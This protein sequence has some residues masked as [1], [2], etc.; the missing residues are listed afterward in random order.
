MATTYATID[1]NAEYYENAFVSTFH[2]IWD[3]TIYDNATDLTDL[4]FYRALTCFLGNNR[5][6]MYDRRQLLYFYLAHGGEFNAQDGDS[7]LNQ[8]RGKLPIDDNVHYILQNICTLYNQAPRRDFGKAEDKMQ[9]IYDKATIDS[10][11]RYLQQIAEVVKVLAVS[12]VIK[13][14]DYRLIYLTPDKFR[15]ETDPNNSFKVTK[16]T[17]TDWDTAR[18]VIVYNEWTADKYSIYSMNIKRDILNR[19]TLVKEVVTETDNVYGIIPFVFLRLTNGSSFIEGGRLDLIEK[20]LELNKLKF[21]SNLDATFNGSPMKLAINMSGKAN[22]ISPNRIFEFEGVKVGEGFNQAPSLEL[23]SNDPQYENLEDFR[24]NKLKQMLREENL[25]AS[26]I[27]EITADI[28]GISRA[29]ERVPLKEKRESEINKFIRFEKELA[30]LIRVIANTDIYLE[31]SQI[32]EIDFKI[33]YEEEGLYLE[34]SLERDFDLN[35]MKNYE[36]HPLNYYSKWGDFDTNLSEDELINEIQIRKE[37]L[38][39]LELEKNNGTAEEN[40]DEENNPNQINEQGFQRQEIDK[41]KEIIN[42]NL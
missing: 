2:Q 25:P 14:N 38:T 30:E 7:L 19:R 15:I 22:K 17:Y 39:K 6:D 31:T 42:N 9:E 13:D 3:G 40:P 16:F 24:S 26:L 33:D 20:Q 34:P 12:I 29:I 27:N 32:P 1:N 4:A 21:L 28:S 11:M 5:I 23:I 35:K 36:L 10:Q 37:L 18:A 41:Q 8:Y